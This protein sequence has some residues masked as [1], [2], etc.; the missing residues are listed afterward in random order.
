M[1]GDCNIRRDL[2]TL[3]AIELFR[4]Q[5]DVDVEEDGWAVYWYPAK[6]HP[7]WWLDK[8]LGRIEE[9]R[10]AWYSKI[11]CLYDGIPEGQIRV[12]VN[13]TSIPT[14]FSPFHLALLADLV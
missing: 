12:Y 13:D 5:H 1:D 10:S 8:V 14:V 2:P 4:S 7:G 3:V 9:I 6:I 11:L